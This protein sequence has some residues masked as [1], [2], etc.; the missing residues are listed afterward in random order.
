MRAL[1]SDT[2][3]CHARPGPVLSGPVLSGPVL[4]GLVLSGLL[5]A[6]C[7]ESGGTDPAPAAPSP[8]EQP[9]EPATATTDAPAPPG[10]APAAPAPSSG[11]TGLP[12]VTQGLVKG[13]CDNGPGNEGADSHFAGSLR[14]SGDA[15]T[16]DERWILFT[17]PKWAARGGKDCEIVWS[18][19]G[20]KTPAPPTCGAC[21]YGVQ[22]KATPDLSRSTCP[23]EMMLGRKA[24]TGETVGGEAVPFEQSYGVQVTGDKARVVFAKSGKHLGEGYASDSALVWVSDHQCKWF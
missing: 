2:H 12:D 16:G 17:N 4:S 19:Q 11:A 10:A 23:E 21:S 5:L 9:A 8:P 18:I 1:P 14:F 3:P 22:F 7:F 15:V 6:G 13:Q 24:P 20:S